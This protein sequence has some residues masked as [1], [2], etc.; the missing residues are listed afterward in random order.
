M[1]ATKI[2]QKP[3][4]EN[5][6]KINFDAAFST[7]NR[8]TSAGIIVRNHNCLV[9]GSCAY[10]LGRSEDST[11][12]EA[13]ACLQ[14]VSFGADLEF[15]NI[16]VEGDLL[17][18]IKKLNDIRHD[19]FVVENIMKVIKRKKSSFLTISFIHISRKANMVV[20]KLVEIRY[21]LYTPIF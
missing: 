14:A 13:L 1:H 4:K 6:V 15:Q 9:M 3:P 21:T 16:V 18:I 7:Q 11:M 8:S 10:P 12:A 19:R 2:V 5:Q 17:S 20:Y